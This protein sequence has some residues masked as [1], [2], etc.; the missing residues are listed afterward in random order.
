MNREPNLDKTAYYQ[1]MQGYYDAGILRDVYTT[2]LYA[3]ASFGELCYIVVPYAT[4]G[5]DAIGIYVNEE[6]IRNI[7]K[8]D[9]RYR[10]YVHEILENVE[11]YG[12]MIY[13]FSTHSVQFWKEWIEERKSFVKSQIN[14]AFESEIREMHSVMTAKKPDL[15]SK[16]FGKRD[17]L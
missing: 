8:S 15:F 3:I 6:A 7:T 11:I 17:N 13:H 4:V 5:D 12:Q 16:L 14:P 1:K 2:D 10:S 9:K